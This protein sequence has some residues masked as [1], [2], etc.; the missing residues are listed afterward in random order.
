MGVSFS[1]LTASLIVTFVSLSLS[2]S[3]M[4]FNEK[5]SVPLA[6]HHKFQKTCPQTDAI[7][8]RVFA[9]HHLPCPPA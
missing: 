1:S 4:K 9:F 7:R 5:L 8:L 2:L 6:F 3:L